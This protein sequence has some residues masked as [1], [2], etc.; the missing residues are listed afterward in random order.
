MNAIKIFLKDESGLEIAEYAVA[1]ALVALA[2]A[3]AFTALGV[4]INSVINVL[5]NTIEAP[6]RPIAS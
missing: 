5:A 3:A 6:L 4:K 1:A 2:V